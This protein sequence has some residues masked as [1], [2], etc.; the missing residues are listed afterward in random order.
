MPVDPSAYIKKQFGESYDPDAD[1]VLAR[2]DGSTPIYRKI[3][4]DQDNAEAYRVEFVETIAS[5]WDF[6]GKPVDERRLQQYMKQLEI[7]P[8]GL[9]EKGIAYAVRNNTFNTVPTI[10]AIWEGVRNELKPLNPRPGADVAELIEEWDKSQFKK[11]VLLN[12]V[13]AEL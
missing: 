8:I 4:C 12:S 6:I 5:L 1:Y 11:C 9:L 7:L 2:W 13:K 10:G 3:G